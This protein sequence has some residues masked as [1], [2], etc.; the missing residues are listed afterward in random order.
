MAH[1][2]IESFNGNSKGAWHIHGHTHCN[3]PNEKRLK[4]LDVG[5][6]YKCSPVSYREIKIEMNKLNGLS[7]TIMINLTFFI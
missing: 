3:L 6:D 4:R 2:P 7:G 5:W 1:Y